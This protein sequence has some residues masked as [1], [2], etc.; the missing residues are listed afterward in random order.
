MIPKQVEEHPQEEREEEGGSEAKGCCTFAIT[1]NHVWFQAIY[2][3]RTCQEQQQHEQEQESNWNT[4]SSSTW[5]CIC[6]SCAYCC[7]DGHEV[8][9][10]GVGPSYCDCSMQT[11]NNHSNCKLLDYSK[12]V[13]RSLHHLPSSSSSSSMVSSSATR[14]TDEFLLRPSPP[15]PDVTS[16]S[17]NCFPYHVTTMDILPLTDHNSS[18][19]QVLIQECQTLVRYTKDTHWIAQSSAEE[20]IST[21]LC[22]LEKLA[23][24]ILKHHLSTIPS[25]QQLNATNNNH[26]T[27]CDNSANNN[28]GAEWWVQVKPSCKNINKDNNDDTNGYR[29]STSTSIDLHYDK[30]ETL[31]EIFGLGSFPTL[32]T[33]TYLTSSGS[34]SSSYSLPQNPTIIFPHCYHDPEDNCISQCILSYPYPGKHLAFDGRLLH[35]APTHSALLQPQHQNDKQSNITE[36]EDHSNSY[37]D[38]HYRVTFLVNI[39]LQGPP[40]GVKTLS[41]N[42]RSLLLFLP[43]AITNDENDNITR[44]SHQYSNENNFIGLVVEQPSST[45]PSI[46]CNMQDAP[47]FSRI[48]IG[49]LITK[50]KQQQEDWERIQ[51][52]FLSKEVNP[53]TV[54]QDDEE[55][56]NSISSFSSSE[57]ELHLSMI[58]PT[59]QY[60]EGIPTSTTTLLVM[61]GNGCEATLQRT[62][63]SS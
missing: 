55:E 20:S 51:L 29:S 32:S 25:L 58:P 44:K 4:T 57:E 23:L 2:S 38:E 63:S 43:T 9:Y 41:E 46:I 26:A 61:Y 16:S 39:W 42:I 56:V 30:D 17:N 18:L 10:I 59:V 7:H 24:C 13:V 8:E 35:G 53:T 27:T 49:N 6:E 50:D 62:T 22:Q 37:S 33:V 15:L 5:W 47:S 52:P 31:A 28:I 48:E 45:L 54:S 14:T 60:W 11:N 40:I 19:R 34:D 12:Q 1:G 36:L 21:P 3:C